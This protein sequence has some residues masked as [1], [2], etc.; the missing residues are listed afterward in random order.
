VV[1]GV[2]EIGVLKL[3]KVCETGWFGT[4]FF[5]ETWLHS[6]TK[7]EGG[8]VGFVGFGNRWRFAKKVLHVIDF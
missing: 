5:L 2:F 7:K 3:K 8:A 4:V 6:L 1:L